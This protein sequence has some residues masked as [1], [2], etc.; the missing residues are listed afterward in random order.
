LIPIG[1][2]QRELIIGDRQTGKSA[3]VLDTILNQ[4]P[5][6][7]GTD[8]SQKLYCVYV[9]IGQKRS[10]VAQFVKTLEEQGAL[11]YSIIVAATASDPAPMQFLAPF[12]GCAMGEYFRDNGMHAVIIYDDLSSRPS[13]TGRCRCCCAVRRAVKPIRATCSTFTRGF[14]SVRPRCRTRPAPAR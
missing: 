7:Q 6:N 3:I 5:L 8:E 14:W 4:K 12:S 2:G 11:E 10:T 1:R 13:R 9:A